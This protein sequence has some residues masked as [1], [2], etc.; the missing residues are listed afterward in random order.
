MG[1]EQAIEG[2]GFFT[3]HCRQIIVQTVATWRW[4]KSSLFKSLYSCLVVKR[5]PLIG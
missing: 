4:Y 2:L 1:F 3:D 5:S